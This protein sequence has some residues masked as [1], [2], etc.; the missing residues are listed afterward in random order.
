MLCCSVVAEPEPAIRFLSPPGVLLGR[1]TNIQSALLYKYIRFDVHVTSRTLALRA[2]DSNMYRT[3]SSDLRM[4][5]I[6]ACDEF[7]SDDEKMLY[8]LLPQSVIHSS[9]AFTITCPF[10]KDRFSSPVP[11][12]FTRS[13]VSGYSR[14]KTTMCCKSR[15]Q[16]REAAYAALGQDASSSPPSYDVATSSQSLAIV[17]QSCCER[18]RARR[19][20]RRDAG[21]T[22]APRKWS[23][24]SM[25]GKTLD[26]QM[27]RDTTSYDFEPDGRWYL[28]LE[29][30]EVC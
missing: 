1:K 10:H 4:S 24:W 12:S 13:P 11:C 28:G 30:V 2:K 22:L 15:R 6:D 21:I 29:S 7:R 20:A 14:P 19:Q 3:A 17:R 5:D 16:Q 18:K 25:F 23:L 26:S 8:N 27:A 9:S